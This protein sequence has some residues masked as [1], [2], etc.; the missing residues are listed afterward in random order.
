M[1]IKCFNDMN[2]DDKENYLS[3][4]D[5]HVEDGIG[6]NSDGHEFRCDCDIDCGL[7]LYVHS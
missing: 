2:K 5:G 4:R 7:S 1:K 3:E 6:L